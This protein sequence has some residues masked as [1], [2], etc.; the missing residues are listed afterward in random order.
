MVKTGQLC[1]P[2]SASIADAAAELYRMP[3]LR[4]AFRAALRRHDFEHD[5]ALILQK[6]YALL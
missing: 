4:Q 1:K 6:L 5:N 2:D 3:E